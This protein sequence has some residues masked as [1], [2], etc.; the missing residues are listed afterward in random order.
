[1]GSVSD[2]TSDS[3]L[4]REKSDVCLVS[5]Q[6]PISILPLDIIVRMHEPDISGGDLGSIAGYSKGCLLVPLGA[7][8]PR[9]SRTMFYGPGNPRRASS[10]RMEIGIADPN[11]SGLNSLIA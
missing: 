2:L 4:I 1:M 10:C 6:C 9:T 11:E 5:G 8:G 3:P 7:Q